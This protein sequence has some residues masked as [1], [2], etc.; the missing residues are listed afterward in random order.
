MTKWR[1]LTPRSPAR[2]LSRRPAWTDYENGSA[3]GRFGYQGA[4]DGWTVRSAGK[5][6]LAT[7]G[8]C[9]ALD[10]RNRGAG[11]PGTLTT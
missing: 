5:L 8:R 1:T 7:G 9:Q 10:I 11:S 6:V 4:Q 2:L 3:D